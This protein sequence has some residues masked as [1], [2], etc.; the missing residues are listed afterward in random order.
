MAAAI[1]VGMA[2]KPTPK[3]NFNIYSKQEHKRSGCTDSACKAIE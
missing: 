2:A 3:G 1:S